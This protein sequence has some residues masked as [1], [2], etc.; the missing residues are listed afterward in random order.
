MKLVVGLIAVLFGVNFANAMP[1]AHLSPSVPQAIA[2]DDAEAFSAALDAMSS[3][4]MQWDDVG[5]FDP[6]SITPE[7]WDMIAGKMAVKIST[8]ACIRAG[9]PIY[10]HVSLAN[11]TV[12]IYENGVPH[13]PYLV[14]SGLPASLARD[15]KNH[16]TKRWDSI[17]MGPTFE[18]YTSHKYPG[19]DWRGYGNMPFVV[20]YYGGF[21]LHGTAATRLLGHRAS[22]GCVRMDPAVAKAFRTRVIQYGLG[23]TW[24]TVD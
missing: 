4:S 11:Q 8:P 23:Q 7:Q 9:C 1:A 2:A 5:E 21:G 17:A 14:S 20:F 10:A 3:D 15:H 24:V 19:G 22:H 13:G 16:L 6:Y 12:M 18:R